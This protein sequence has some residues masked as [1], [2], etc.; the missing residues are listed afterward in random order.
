M[1]FMDTAQLL[2]NLGEFIGSIVIV[3]TLIYLAIQVRQNTRATRLESSRA[4]TSEFNSFLDMLASNRELA[5][6]WYGGL[7]NYQSLDDTDKMRFTLAVSR[8][9]RT[10]QEGFMEWREGA[11]DTED[12]QTI[13]KPFM[14][15]L[16]YHGF[17]EVWSKRKHHYSN[18]FQ[19]FVDKVI[20]ESTDAKPLYDASGS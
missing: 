5:D 3:A 16:R 2:G 4:I 1:S 9:V 12:W 6:I 19:N 14:D 7:S 8:V 15:L 11:M 18:D 13:A 10:T 17:R 20:A